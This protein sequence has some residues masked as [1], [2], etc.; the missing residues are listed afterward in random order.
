MSETGAVNYN[1]PGAYS[2]PSLSRLFVTRDRPEPVV[3]IQL[4]DEAHYPP[5]TEHGEDDESEESELEEEG[6]E[7]MS[8]NV[9]VGPDK[10]HCSWHSDTAQSVSAYSRELVIFYLYG[11]IKPAQGST[12]KVTASYIIII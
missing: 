6:L 5:G 8:I 9:A 12:Y 10:A 11:R 4:Q 1:G 2:E 7:N 3:H